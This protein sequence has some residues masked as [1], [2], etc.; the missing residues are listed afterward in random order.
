MGEYL[1]AGEI[2]IR[3]QER[4]CVHMCVSIPSVSTHVLCVCGYSVR[5]GWR[6]APHFPG[7]AVLW[8]NASGSRVLAARPGVP[9]SRFACSSHTVEK[10]ESM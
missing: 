10:S 5:R 3:A 1:H 4:V 6:R 2:G 7:L 8:R 9:Y